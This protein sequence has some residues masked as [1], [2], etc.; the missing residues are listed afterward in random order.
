MDIVKVPAYSITPDRLVTY[1]SLEGA[2]RGRQSEG[3]ENLKD[4]QNKYGELS[5]GA[6]RRMNRAL[7][8]MFYMERD[9]C[10][11]N[12]KVKRYK[13]ENREVMDLTKGRYKKIVK[14]KFTFITLTLPSAQ[15]HTDEDIKSYYFNHFLTVLRRDYGVKKYIWKAEK[16]K[17]KNIHFHIIADKFIDWREIRN[18]WN[19]IIN[20]PYKGKPGYVDVY[21]QRMQ[22]YYADGF[23]ISMNANDKRTTNEQVKAYKAGKACNWTDPNSTDIHALYNVGNVKAYVQKYVSKNDESRVKRMKEIEQKI[24][25]LENETKD[26][27][28]EM[29]A[30]NEL[31]ELNDQL[32][33]SLQTEFEELKSRGVSG[34]IW[35]ASQVV[36]K[37][38]SVSDIGYPPDIDFI[39]SK[40][41]K[42]VR[43]N[44]E[45]GMKAY[46]STDGMIKKYVNEVGTDN[47]V[48]TYYI[49][50]NNVPGLKFMLD[51][52]ISGQVGETLP[53]PYTEMKILN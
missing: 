12:A 25:D 24:K 44:E 7:D 6:K 46:I 36:S 35:N 48:V 8:F 17:N 9:K 38:K 29:K 5:P 42:L 39:K 18:R 47:M 11:V 1:N 26:F 2:G 43:I 41:Y 33:L 22:E 27:E 13:A 10:L 45:N 19:K 14:Y 15:Q 37:L 53:I 20:K 28:Y 31:K 21:S 50:F 16:Q 23:R 30:S 32:L 51:N 52:Y 4:N 40:S 49:D 3:E 34:R